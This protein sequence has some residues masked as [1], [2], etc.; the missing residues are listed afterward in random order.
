MKTT[1][2]FLLLVIALPAC[3]CGHPGVGIVR[4][5][6]GNIFYTDLAQVWKIDP[7]GKRTVAV[8]HVH[9]HELYLDE[10]DN[11]FGE[12]LWYNGEQRNTW[13]HFVWRLSASGQYEKIIPD[14]EGFRQG[15]SFVRD[16]M[17]HHYYADRQ[18]A[19]QTIY[20]LDVHG[21]KQKHTPTCFHR[22]GWMY[23]NA[24]GDLI[25]TDRQQLKTI[26]SSGVRTIASWKRGA[27]GVWMDSRGNLYA[28]CYEDQQVKCFD[29][30][31]RALSVIQTE[32]GWHPSGGLTEPDGTLWILENNANNHV[33]VERVR[34]AGQRTVW[35]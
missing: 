15:Y 5:T 26:T 3:V 1:F 9:T 8:A 14:T 2:T 10:H 31:G 22:V 28:A 7:A 21:Q 18:G 30:A 35:P 34:P 32:G 16:Q 13:G 20:R 17:G 11:L 27:M 24:Q 12:H 33:R 4:D 6:R 23:A 29:P 19:C 25:F